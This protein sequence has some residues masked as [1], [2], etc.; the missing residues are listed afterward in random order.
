MSFNPAKKEK[1]FLYRTVLLAVV[2][3]ASKMLT[4]MHEFCTQLMTMSSIECT[5]RIDTRLY[6]L[7]SMKSITD[8]TA[9]II[10]LRLHCHTT[11]HFDFVEESDLRLSLD[12]LRPVNALIPLRPIYSA[13]T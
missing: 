7:M 12:P 5:R 2:D 8:N 10:E 13:L 11:L 6:A 3:K 9:K 4:V 1:K